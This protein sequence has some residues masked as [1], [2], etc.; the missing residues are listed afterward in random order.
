MITYASLMSE[1]IQGKTLG[2]TLPGPRRPAVGFWA[3]LNVR[4]KARTHGARQDAAAP[5]IADDSRASA[6]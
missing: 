6:L 2:S 1:A 3:W 5:R 4:A